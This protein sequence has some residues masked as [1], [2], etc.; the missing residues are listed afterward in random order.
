MVANLLLDSAADLP[1]P[2][3]PL[4]GRERE[5]AAL[6]DL[7]LRADV[8]LVTL[9][10]P[11]GVGKTRLALHVAA[12]LA[13]A[14]ADGVR[15]VP[16]AAIRDPD[17]VLPTIAQAL[18]L[19][20]LGGQSPAAGLRILLREREVLL[21]LDNMEQIV[22]AAPDL[23]GIRATCPGLTLLVTS[24]E[25]LRIEGEQEFPVPPLAVPDPASQISTAD[26]ASCEAVAYFLQRAQ[27]VKPDFALT[28]EEAPVIAE[29]CT[30][31]DGLPLAI[32]LAASRIKVLSPQALL[33]R[34]SDR[35]TLL[36]RDARDLPARLRTMRDAIAWSYELLSPREQSLFRRLA[37]FPGGCTTDAAE[38]MA[39]DGS[40]KSGVEATVATPDSR[41]PTPYSTC[42]PRSWT[43]VC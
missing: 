10:G 31:L 43:R 4:I 34:L 2:R 19:T 22:S 15:F 23:A 20:A 12:D 36:S 30:R 1:L 35:L 42:L 18:G 9:T 40:R 5:R 25:T 39:G 13:G 21:V 32:E 27:A 16:L 3:T 38:A 7:L 14:F 33:A 37:V 8:P 6:R 11:G 28:A 26:L 41:L 29:I 24:R 17:L